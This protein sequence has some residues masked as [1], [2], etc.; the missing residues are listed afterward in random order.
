MDKAILKKFAIESRKDLIEKIKNKINMFYIDEEF[1]REQKGELYVLSNGKHSLNLTNE[2]FKKREL[3]IKR[4]KELSLEQVIEEAA[5]TWFNRIIAIRYMEINDML[6]LTRDNQSLGIRVLSSKD[7]TTDPEIL[8]FSNLMNPDMDIDFK[9]EKYVELKDDNEK[10]K[11]VLLLVCKKLGRVIPQV[12]DGVTDYIDILIPD[13]LLNDTGFVAKVINEVPESNYNQVE[14]IGWLYQYYN[15]T[16]KDRVISAK[17]AYKKNEIPYVTQLF[18]PDWIV[19]Y[20]VENSL[21]RYWVEHNGDGALYPLGNLYTSNNLYP[22]SSITDNW[23][24]FIKENIENKKEKL[25]PTEITFI[26]PCC[27]S[28]HILVYAFE[29]FY[30]IYLQTGYNKKDIPELIL[31]NN[32]YGLDID[33]R[34]GQLSILSILL[35]AREYDKQIF[36]KEIVRNIN[37]MSIQESNSI[38]Q[39]LIDNINDENSKK[40][41]QYLL[42]NFK[43]TKEIGSLLILEDKSYFE[44]ESYIYDDTT[45]LGIELRERLLPII[46]I[47]KILSKKYDVVATN[48]PY[49]G[50]SYMSVNLKKYINEHYNEAKSDLC[51]SFMQNKLIKENGL[52]A[53]I[54][55]HSWMF[56]SSFEKL[57]YD[58]INNKTILNMVHLGTRAFEEIGG[59]VVQTSTF[60]IKNA[61]S[62]NVTTFIRLVNYE[63]AE[64]KEIKFLEDM[65]T[66][67]D[68]F[69]RNIKDFINIPGYSMAYWVSDNF[70][71]CFDNKK[72]SDYGTACVG[73]Q[74][75]DNSR[76][77]REWYEVDK[78]KIGFN[79]SSIDESISSKKKWFP[80]NKGGEYRKWYGNTIEVVN[81][82]NNGKEIREYN[83]YLNATRTSNIGIANT[84]YYFKESGTWGLVSSARFSVRYSPKG[85]IFDTGGSSLFSDN[86]K[87]L[88]G[89]LNTKIVQEIMRIQNPTLN[90]QPG[91]VSKIPIIIDKVNEVELFVEQNINLSKKDWD[92]FEISWDFKRHPL[93]E[94]IDS[95]PGLHDSNANVP[96]THLKIVKNNYEEECFVADELP[97]KA[98]I[99]DSFRRWKEYTEKQFS[100]LKKNEEEL[101]KIFIDIYGLQDELTPDEEDKDVT[102]RK[103]D[104]EREIKSLIS[105]AVGCM[106]GRYSLEKDGLIYAG[107]D[108]DKVY[109]KYKGE[110]GGWAGVSLAN[111][112]VL[113]DNGKEIDLSFEV[114]N[115]NVIPIT[116]EAYFG[117]D[118]VERFKKFISVVYGKETLN[119]NLDFIAETL[120]KKG[121]ETSEET[122]RRY[123]VNDFFKDHVKIYQKRPIYWLFDSGKKN[124]FKAL[125]YMHRYNE[126]LVPKIRLDYL[127]RMQT[128]YEKLLSD[129]NYKLTTELSMTDKKEAQKRQADLNAK[130]QEIKEY[131]EKIAHIANQRISIDLDDGVKV[132][133]E[134]FK[135]ILA[136][137]K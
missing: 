2:E 66:K 58:I 1:S 25:N 101:N 18:T 60:V 94:F 41:A 19:K 26:D 31:K 98:R 93:L 118:I 23:K 55:Q 44:L 69:H 33:D 12:F 39:S 56:L 63:N 115:D 112:T 53:M 117:D 79:M 47:A 120:G 103:A 83:N 13:N 24:Y 85:A 124:G 16:E 122:I 91:N 38:S 102:I 116:D 48:P 30:Q 132:N 127:H 4:I 109:K 80:Y 7:N 10:F 113:N 57:R 27:G 99:S 51:T 75:S 135:D 89:L 131:D 70:I 3:L 123:F 40:Q 110:N 50:Q 15:Q 5:Y 121:T 126:N 22:S 108:F 82:E 86:I 34:A 78:D 54:N 17:K 133:Y 77:L 111:Y 62:N 72:L 96:P 61:I 37:V 11:Y 87:Y 45:I 43:D 32:L 134:K 68:F 107:G 21:G 90:F 42:D 105:Y 74:T 46:K 76:F 92:S 137:I 65:T 36:N 20:M 104:Q 35:K 88:I 64:L 29:V 67:T 59:E 128:T 136:K 84:Q 125:I 130:L 95:M 73:L 8:K 114:D 119:E 14:I 52:I 129:I 9:K 106:F 97:M 6:P 100:T 49:M 28:G 71:K 81:W